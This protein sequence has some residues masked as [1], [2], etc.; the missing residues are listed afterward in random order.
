MMQLSNRATESLWLFIPQAIFLFILPFT[1]TVSLRL[2]CLFLALVLVLILWKRYA[3]PAL[4]CKLPVVLWAI[5]ALLSLTYTV[6]VP[7]SAREVKNEIGY[8]LAAFAVF[9]AAAN[10]ARA[11]RIMLAVMTTGFV[12]LSL[13]ALASYLETRRWNEAG[14][15]GGSASYASYF[16][17]V[18]PF[19]LFFLWMPRE[20]RVFGYLAA[21]V[22][23]ALGLACAFFT[24]QRVV[25]PVL[26]LQAGV[27]VF[28]LHRGRLIKT[29][30]KWLA[31]GLII[32]LVGSMFALQTV[33]QTR[34][35]KTAFLS[36]TSDIRLTK[37]EAIAD[38]IM[39]KP[40]TGHGFGRR[41][42]FKTHPE[43]AQ[44]LSLFWHAHNI[45]LTYGVQ[46]GI[47]GILVIAA[48]FL[49]LLYQFYR[50]YRS[51]DRITSLLGVVGI[52]LVIGVLARNQ[53]NDMFSRDLSLLFAS[54][55]GLLLGYGRRRLAQHPP[56]KP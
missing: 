40:L 31:T 16:L 47:P 48:L 27:A 36:I 32:G 11:F 9:Y 34:F 23:V 21:M 46:L 25:W 44:D 7:H 20:Q 30:G 12:V 42:L 1:H 22:L 10:N 43:L 2:L 37:T 38:I 52:V 56:G 13:W 45:F 19:V 3:P 51:P 5:L 54:L 4:P 41:M 14:Y 33:S 17:T 29:P 49:C 39:E 15:F 53:T 55:A 35:G 26:V 8:V 6:D 24:Y 18:V 50:L 28:L